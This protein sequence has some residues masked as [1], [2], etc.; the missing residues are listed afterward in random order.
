MKDVENKESGE[1]VRFYETPEQAMVADYYGMLEM[2]S[3]FN[4]SAERACER[5]GFPNPKEKA[6]ELTD[7]AEKTAR[8]LAGRP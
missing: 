8:D 1:G 3:A 5:L 4:C 6:R 7:Y 2:M